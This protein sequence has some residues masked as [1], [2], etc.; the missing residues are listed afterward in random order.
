MDFLMDLVQKKG[1]VLETRVIEGDLHLQERELMDDFQADI[2]FNASGLGA[3]T[4]ANDNQFFNENAVLLPAQYDSNGEPSKTIFIVPRKEAIAAN[5]PGTL[6]VGSIIQR[7]NWKLDNLTVES[8][9]V[10]AMWNRAKNFAKNLPNDDSEESTDQRGFA[11]G[12]RPF[13]HSNVRVSADGRTNSCK[14]VHNYGHGG[15]GWTLAVGCAL[16]CVKVLEKML[17]DEVSGSV[18]NLV[19]WNRLQ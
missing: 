18:A 9:E 4:L 1:A 6:V 2:I 19:V 13:S 7:N 12:L 11:K 14:V 15:S 5:E 10:T 16:T 8:P 3:H 17:H